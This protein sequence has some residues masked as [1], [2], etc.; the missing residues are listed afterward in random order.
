VPPALG[1]TAAAGLFGYAMLG[2]ALGAVAAAIAR[3][4]RRERPTFQRSYGAVIR[5]GISVLAV[6]IGAVFVL[7]AVY[8]VMLGATAISVFGVTALSRSWLPLVAPIALMGVFFGITFVALILAVSTANSLCAVVVEKRSAVASARLTMARIVNRREFGRALLCAF[9]VC[10]VGVFA[11]TVV[12]LAALL[13]LG[14]WPGASVALGALERAVVVPF[15]AA[16]FV[17]YYFDLRIRYEGY[18]LDEQEAVTDP[19]E[20]VYAPTA[21]L[22]GAERAAIKRFLE[23]RDSLAPQRRNEIA[24]RLAAAPRTRVPPELARLDDESLLERL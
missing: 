3:I 6:V 2:F 18:G 1:L 14:R 5:S 16:V 10:A 12:D 22:S 4:Y 11:S 24:A 7:V 23:R 13:G 8:A 9:A 15:L 17:I 20:P 21:Y 19:A